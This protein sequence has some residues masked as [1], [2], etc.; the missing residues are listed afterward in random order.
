[1]PRSDKE[2]YENQVLRQYEKEMVAKHKKKLDFSHF[3]KEMRSMSETRYDELEKMILEKTIR[4]LQTAMNGGQ[5][6]SVELVTF[7]L[8]RIEQY[9]PL[10]NA[11]IELNPDALKLAEDV[12]RDRKK[13]KGKTLLSG[14]PILLKDN[15][16]TGDKMHN[17]AGA[18]ALEGSRLKK[19]APIVKKIKEYGGI[20]LGKSNMSEW[21]FQMSSN[22]VNGYSALGGQT[23]NPYG[24][25]DVGGSSSGSAV[26]VAMNLASVTIGSETCGSI[27]YP[28]SQNNIVGLK[29][30][31][32]LWRS[33]RI[34]PIAKSFDTA[35]PL[36][37][38]VEDAAL[39]NYF[40]SDITDVN[41]GD[42]ESNFKTRPQKRFKL[43]LID[44]P[45]IHSYYRNEDE[46]LLDKAVKDLE[47][48]GFVV[49]RIMI[50]EKAFGV[51]LDGPLEY[52][53]K[54]CVATYLKE[55][56]SSKNKISSLKNIWK[57]NEKD[58][59]SRAPYGQDL[60]K[61]SAYTRITKKECGKTI[62]RDRRICQNAI[63]RQL[64]EYDGLISL[65]NHFSLVYA[66][67]GY[68]ALTVPGGFRSTGEPVGL[69]FVGGECEED[70]L[71]TMGY[72]YEQGTKHRRSYQCPR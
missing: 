70:K 67:A 24:L 69:T 65:S 40:L 21:A 50:D 17:T 11:I 22:G 2:L 31:L 71:I 27:I 64:G 54:K 4:E 23:K 32:G 18:K 51:D 16:G 57:Y 48:L 37:R 33:K 56:D 39:I 38:S 62:K 44:N 20:I 28:A 29:P 1:M 13:D 26:G 15:I 43:G 45:I 66:Y 52:E 63:D 41:D 46:A 30:T 6:T 10:L 53:F 25:F 58:L 47:D 34:V 72:I 42:F 59:M 12:D 36:T 60:I 5:F 55:T 68:P 7:Y 3:T 61:N 19:D 14:I 9:N 35:G 49:D 8:K